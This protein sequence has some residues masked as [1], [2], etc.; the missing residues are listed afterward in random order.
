MKIGDL[1]WIHK[2]GNPHIFLG[3]QGEKDSPLREDGWARLLSPSGTEQL[4]HCD[5]IY[6]SC[7]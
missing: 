5:Y 2:H 3:W 4:V 7:K 1:V 6:R